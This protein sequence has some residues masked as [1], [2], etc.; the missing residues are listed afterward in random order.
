[1]GPGLGGSGGRG[2]EIAAKVPSSNV[3]MR[4]LFMSS[5]LSDG[6]IG[7]TRAGSVIR[8]HQKARFPQK[9]CICITPGSQTP[10]FQTVGSRRMP[11]PP[12]P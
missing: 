4:S 7:Q 2:A 3:V 9:Q 10:P 8:M 11:Y 1:V 12:L 5:V 6:S